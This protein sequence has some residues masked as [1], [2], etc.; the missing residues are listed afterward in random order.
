MCGHGAPASV[1]ELRRA[2]AVRRR[3]PWGQVRLKFRTASVPRAACGQE[4]RSLRARCSRPSRR[5]PAPSFPPTPWAAAC[6]ADRPT[7]PAPSPHSGDSSCERRM[8]QAPFP[9]S[10]RQRPLRTCAWSPA[11][12]SSHVAHTTRRAWE[13]ENRTT[14][15]IGRILVDSKDL[16]HN[17][18]QFWP[19]LAGNRQTLILISA[20]FAQSWPHSGQI[21]TDF[22]GFCIEWSQFRLNLARK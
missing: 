20:N 6:R 19:T 21:R 7:P 11:A 22:G 16:G 4:R 3:P 5:S 13:A 1:V 18:A 2:N 15:R 17:S 12:A 8:S 14:T 10:G 9:L